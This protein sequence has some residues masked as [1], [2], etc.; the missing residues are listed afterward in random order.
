ME[1]Q[2]YLNQLAASTRPMKKSKVSS[3]LSSKLFIFGIIALAILIV[4]IIIG[5]ILSGNKSDEKTLGIALKLHV[6]N[7]SS[8][9]QTYQTNIKSSD[10]RSSSASLNSILSNTSRELTEYLTEVHSFDEKKVEEKVLAQA[11]EARDAL[12]AELFEAKINGI[13]DRIFA[14]KM[15]YEISV[16][17]SEEARLINSTKNDGLTELLKT[18]YDSLETLYEKFNEF[19]ETK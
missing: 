8:I 18:S 13:L 4:T 19:S 15:T 3:I 9:V 1:G 17:M 6:D 11:E 10:L 7:T 16:L 14:H 2:E 12:D 5:S